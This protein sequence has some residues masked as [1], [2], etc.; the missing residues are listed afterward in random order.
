MKIPFN[1][2]RAI[3]DA[4]ADAQIDALVRIADEQKR[5]A[6]IL[7]VIAD[8]LSFLFEQRGGAVYPSE[9]VT[10]ICKGF[11]KE[12]DRCKSEVTG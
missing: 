7:C 1:E 12:I 4:N 8:Q 2:D 11:L 9:T 6:D 5:T 3:A 10:D